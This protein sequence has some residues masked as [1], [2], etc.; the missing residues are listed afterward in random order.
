MG[1][2]SKTGKSKK[3]KG[4]V[5]ETLVEEETMINEKTRVETMLDGTD[6][7]G[8]EAGKKSI[9]EEAPESSGA[10]D[11]T[12][13]RN[14]TPTAQEQWDLMKGMMAQL[15]T[16]TKAVVADPVVL[17]V[18]NQKDDDSEVVEVNP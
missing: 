13:N 2:S 14:N 16:L 3:D 11:N 7:A 8:P 5:E 1:K 18:D 6:S 9:N 12:D 17:K 15:A 10:R 4:I